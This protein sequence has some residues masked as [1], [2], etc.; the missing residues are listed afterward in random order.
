MKEGE[1]GLTGLIRITKGKMGMG[2]RRDW[3][4][5]KEAT[6]M[7]YLLKQKGQKWWEAGKDERELRKM[8]KRGYFLI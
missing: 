2:D 7:T 5:N 3:S 1:G 6:K 8:L 4:T